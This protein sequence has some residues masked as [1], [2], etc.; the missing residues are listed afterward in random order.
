MRSN[1]L[2]PLD[3]RIIEI[4]Q[5]EGRMTYA[6]IGTLAGVSSTAAHERIKKLEARGVITGYRASVDPAKVGA[7]VTAFIFVSQTAGP[8]GLLEEVFDRMPAVEECHRIAGEETLL[9]KV[10]APSMEALDDVVWEI[11]EL[12]AVE[13]TRTVVVL[14]TVFEDRPVNPM[15]AE[16]EP[17]V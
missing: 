13:R 17:S 7:E 14:A 5:R 8:R 3:R 10:R 4:L 2:T 11:R 12:E 6:Q 15:M 1:D 9:I 16:A